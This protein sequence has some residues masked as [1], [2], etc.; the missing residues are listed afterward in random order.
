MKHLLF[1]IIITSLTAS[2]QISNPSIFKDI[3]HFLQKTVSNGRVDYQALSTNSS[4][5]KGLIDALENI[6]LSQASDAESKALYINAYNLH[7]INQIVQSYPL[8]S[9]QEVDGFF[10]RTK[11]VVAGETMTLNELET[12]K[13]IKEYQDPRFHFVLV[14]G[15]LGCPPITNFAYTPDQLDAQMTGQTKKALND[16]SFIQ[17]SSD[18]VELS[19]LFS[20]YATDFGGNKKSILSFIN[21]YRENPLSENTKIGYYNYDWSLNVKESVLIEGTNSSRYI[22]SSTIR[23]GSMEI[24]LFNNLYSQKTGDGTEL[25]NRSSFFT[26]SLSLF[27][28]LTNRFNIGIASR[29][30]KVRNNNL[31]SSPFSVFGSGDPGTTRRGITAIGPQIRVA[32]IKKWRNFSIQSAFTFAVGKELTGN[33]NEPYIDWNG[34][35]WVTQVFNDFSIGN[36]FSLFTEIDLWI[37]DIGPES[38][39]RIN[40]LS[41][42]VTLIFSYVPTNKISLYVL[43]GFSPYWQEEFDYFYQIG[44]GG[45]YQFTPNFELELLFT[46]FTNKFLA[47]NNG[48]AA[49]YNLGI[50]TNIQSLKRD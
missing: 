16:E 43:N 46:D 8:Q 35:T 42:P 41:T 39:N 48:Q 4:E 2:A 25:L 27:Y 15:A 24:K 9:V 37:E 3:D 14:C 21:A 50:R 33:A 40:R 22:V 49:T 47:D 31:P 5:L 13:L 17:V 10:N 45:K 38:E 34:P 12:Q 18:Q 36:K 19:E 23:K 44:V 29:Y 1:L 30:R 20:W 26:S 7:V 32:P 11:I 6:D 28:G